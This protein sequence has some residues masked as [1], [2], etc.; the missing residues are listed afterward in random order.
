MSKVAVITVISLLDGF[1]TNIEAFDNVT[2][3]EE[4]FKEEV[5]AHSGMMSDDE[6]TDD[7]MD[8]YLEDG[9]YTNGTFDLCLMHTYGRKVDED[10]QRKTV[11]YDELWLTASAEH[12]CEVP[13]LE[14]YQQMTD[15]VWDEWVEE[16]A[17]QLHEYEDANQINEHISTTKYSMEQLL[18]SQGVEVVR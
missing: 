11:S 1:P 16:N 6:I 5:I 2:E 18:K 12:L 7:A 4:F 15:E 3:A 14:T 13:D 8:I 17:T 10:E 9:T